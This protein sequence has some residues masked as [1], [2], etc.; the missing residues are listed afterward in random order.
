[1][2][3]MAGQLILLTV[4]VILG[5]AVLV[6][7]AFLPHASFDTFNKYY[8]LEVRVSKTVISPL[9]CCVARCSFRALC[10]QSFCQ[11]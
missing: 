4:V 5:T 2:R 7:L 10:T 11:R 3:R 9:K 8:Y 6:V 1:M